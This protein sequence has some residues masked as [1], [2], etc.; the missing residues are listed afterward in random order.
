[1]SIYC[2]Q[3]E[4]QTDEDGNPICILCDEKL[5]SEHDWIEHIELEKS[6]LAKNIASL[7]D[8]KVTCDNLLLSPI[9]EQ[10]RRKREYE[11]LRIR[12]NQQKRL[13]LKNRECRD[14]CNSQLNRP[15][16]STTCSLIMSQTVTDNRSGSVKKN[17]CEAQHP[18]NN[19]FCR[20]CERHHEYLIIS[21]SFDHPRCH[22]CFLK[23]RSQTGVLPLSITSPVDCCSPSGL[24][25]GTSGKA[26]SPH[27]PLSLVVEQKRS[28]T[29]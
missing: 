14:D 26:S 15:T 13:A 17:D 1:M 10:C 21:S 3:N 24:S 27:S 8:Y 6:K 19:N 5:N 11:L 7:K 4:L 9:S 22:D 25:D 2:A 20:F 29:E 12:S 16:N 23:L 18:T 28:R